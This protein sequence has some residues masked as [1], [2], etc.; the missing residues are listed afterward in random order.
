MYGQIVA[1]CDVY[2]ALTSE[3]V[4]KKGMHPHD[5]LSIILNEGAKS[6]NPDFLEKFIQLTQ[7]DE[8]RDEDL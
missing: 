5:A 3:R 2:D 4:Y 8:T 7:K 1:I 6:F